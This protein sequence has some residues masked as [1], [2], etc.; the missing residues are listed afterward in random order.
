MNN[1]LLF[2][3]LSFLGFY[4][5]VKGQSLHEQKLVAEFEMKAREIARPI[6]YL[7]TDKDI[8][9]SGE[10]L[11]FKFSQLN[12]QFLTPYLQDSILYLRLVNQITR[13]VFWE[14]KYAITMGFSDGM[15]LINENVKP[16][17]YQVEAYSP[18]AVYNGMKYFNAF[19]EIEIRQFINPEILIRHDLSGKNDY[20]DTLNLIVSDKLGNRLE[21]AEVLISFLNE[22]KKN[23]HQQTSYTNQEGRLKVPLDVDGS[24]LIDLNITLG[25]KHVFE[26]IGL[27]HKN[28]SNGI[29]LYPESGKLINNQ[30]SWVML[31]F[32]DNSN[33]NEFREGV[34]LK[35]G[36]FHQLIKID[37]DG[38]AKLK[39][40]PDKE[41]SYGVVWNDTSSD[42]LIVF[43]QIEERGVT[44]NLNTLADTLLMTLQTSWPG[45]KHFIRLQVRG[46]V[47]VFQELILQENS[48]IKI[49]LT[50]IPTGIA[51]ITV[52]N[53]ESK[54]LG[55]RLNW[56]ENN[57]KLILEAELKQQNYGRR[58]K[59]VVSLTV[60]NSKGQPLEG[61]QLG[62]AVFDKLYQN[63]KY[64]RSLYTT[65]HLLTQ[66]EANPKLESILGSAEE[67]DVWE[68]NRLLESSNKE[69]YMWLEKKL[70][71]NRFIEYPL[72][73]KLFGQIRYKNSKKD[74]DSNYA[75]LFRGDSESNITFIPLDD[76]GSF[77]IHPEVL[78]FGQDEY[79]YIKAL[80]KS[81][82]GVNLLIKDPF[83]DLTSILNTVNFTYPSIEYS[84]SKQK[85]DFPSF[86]RG[87]ILLSEFVVRG[88][89]MDQTRE[90]FIGELAERTKLE[91]N[92]DFVCK[93]GNVLNCPVCGITD[94]KPV[95]GQEYLVLTEPEKLLNKNNNGNHYIISEENHFKYIKY[96]YPNYSDEE[97]LKMYNMTRTRGF[98]VGAEFFVKEYPDKVSKNDSESDYRNTLSWNPY[99]FT[100][101]E[102]KVE[103]EFY[104]SDI[105]SIFSGNF[106]ALSV[107]GKIG[108]VNFE[109]VVE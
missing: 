34:L 106:E 72:A 37:K 77:E 24:Q 64:N 41:S 45:Q 95:E 12:G 56:I 108:K 36:E 76:E 35:N 59:I 27:N 109:F 40:K 46:I 4:F 17:I 30:E 39:V 99:L 18:S 73:N 22:N 43:D 68:I 66:L 58:E 90:K 71:N 28:S 85:L 3:S 55:E 26:R 80:P 60:R 94:R 81:S 21:N 79:L 75:L 78:G 11:Y 54:L 13:E 102:G 8:Y 86:D 5:C 74:S 98:F 1:R 31:S 92:N 105:R 10:Q 25:N 65:A 19:K 51:E 48:K 14:E 87:M 53:E 2:F 88:K 103:I 52:F 61:I 23:L 96:K 50:K 15:V 89:R 69:K 7:Q 82:N 29:T 91:F 33:Q 97:L 57:G 47:Y 104:T 49:P 107:D 83:D 93:F 6:E 67:N 20:S 38:L 16:S 32:T 101:N 62:G 42:T 70:E 63:S 84:S 100:D 9:E 44:I